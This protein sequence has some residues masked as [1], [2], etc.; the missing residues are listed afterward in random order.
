M[1]F[2]RGQQED[3][4]AGALFDAQKVD[5]VGI[6]PDGTTV[7]LYIVSES[8]WTGSDAQINSLQAKIQTYVGYALDGL[9]TRAY[10]ETTGLPWRIVLRCRRGAPGSRT[11]QVL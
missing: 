5:L 4:L 11:T 6:S 10:P 9:M 8:A 7:C 1:P 3:D 2:R